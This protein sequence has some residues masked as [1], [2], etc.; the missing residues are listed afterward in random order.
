[1][2]VQFLL[3]CFRVSESDVDVGVSELVAGVLAAAEKLT[4]RIRA[5]LQRC[6]KNFVFIGGFSR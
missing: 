3:W 2:A 5:S 4:I 1:V 6:R